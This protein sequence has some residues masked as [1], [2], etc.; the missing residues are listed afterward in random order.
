[1]FSKI[2]F[3]FLLKERCS[4]WH[5]HTYQKEWIIV[6]IYCWMSDVY[7]SLRGKQRFLSTCFIFASVLY[8]HSHRGRLTRYTETNLVQISTEVIKFETCFTKPMFKPRRTHLICTLSRKHI[9]DVVMKVG[10]DFQLIGQD[11][12][13]YVAMHIQ[14]SAELRGWWLRGT[15]WG[16]WV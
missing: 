16:F 3:R 2:P 13:W 5:F 12:V 9:L 14:P 8:T 10:L 1:M 4:Q 7:L 6:F 15:H 11:S